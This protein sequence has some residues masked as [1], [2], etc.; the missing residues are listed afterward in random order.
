MS[1]PTAA[2]FEVFRQ[3]L[4]CEE[5]EAIEK[6]QG[7][8]DKIIRSYQIEGELPDPSIAS[9]EAVTD[10]VRNF[11]QAIGKALVC[12]G[13]VFRGLS[14]SRYCP[15][16]ISYLRFLIAGPDELSFP[17]HDS[18]SVD[19]QIARGFCMTEVDDME[20]HLAVLLRIDSLTS[21]FLKPFVH[22]HKDEGEVVLLK[23]AKYRK[24]KTRRS[25]D[26]KNG[27]EYWEVDLVE[28][29]VRDVTTV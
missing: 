5:R 19:E 9:E 10:L 12:R 13:P 3:S 16:C 14:A 18:A 8:W 20:K 29:P 15:K 21:R 23:G 4:T 27:L 22:K 11:T 1:M 17:S 6:W 24:V 25:P 28:Q 2:D 26:P 7:S